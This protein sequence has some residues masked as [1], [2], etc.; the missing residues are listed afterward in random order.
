MKV[1][2]ALLFMSPIFSYLFLRAYDEFSYEIKL[3]TGKYLYGRRTK[4][5]RAQMEL[6][7]PALVE[8]FSI[9]ISGGLSP[10]SAL[11]KIGENSNGE[12]SRVIRPIIEE[13]RN[14]LNFSG[15]L[16]ALT[17]ATGLISVRRFAD[18][19]VIAVQRGTP[20]ADVVGR[21]IAE[22]R[23]SQRLKNLERAGKAE[24]ALMIPVVF[25]ILPVSILFALWP[26]YYGLSGVMGFS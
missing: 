23:N 8:V 12:I 19:L 13:M 26:S 9:L 20:L 7:F 25:L 24:I 10:S 3:S 2:F 16:D 18:S 6:E 11:Q 5:V 1:F 4:K 15:A 17:Q 22:I 21:Q 14:G